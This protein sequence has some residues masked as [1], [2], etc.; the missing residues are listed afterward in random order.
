MKLSGLGRHVSG[1]RDGDEVGPV[2]EGDSK[3]KGDGR[4]ERED[5]G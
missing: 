3:S 4:W 1:E 5:N 2:R